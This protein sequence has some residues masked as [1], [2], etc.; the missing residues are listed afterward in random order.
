MAS[1]II[2]GG[3]G[4]GKL[5]TVPT[6]MVTES[7][8][9]LTFKPLDDQLVG[10]TVLEGLAGFPKATLASA[11]LALASNQHVSMGPISSMIV[12]NSPP[13]VYG[14]AKSAQTS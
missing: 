13:T 12:C 4:V 6:V 8:G 1:I 10:E 7:L 5:F 11:V 3:N 14:V 2:P 9:S